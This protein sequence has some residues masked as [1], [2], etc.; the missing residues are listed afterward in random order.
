MYLQDETV[1]AV[2]GQPLELASVDLPLEQVPAERGDGDPGSPVDQ[3]QHAEDQQEHPP[4]PQD[5]EVLL[6][7]EVV[8]QDTELV[9]DR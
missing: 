7:E 5:E 8:A 4:Q 3:A 1:A 6:V 9:L 2:H